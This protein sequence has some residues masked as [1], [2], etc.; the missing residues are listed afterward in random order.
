MDLYN[1]AWIIP[2][3]N[4]A[5][6]RDNYEYYDF[7]K[8]KNAFLFLLIDTGTHI[9]RIINYPE[10]FG[11]TYEYIK[12]EYKKYDEPLYHEGDARRE[13]MQRCIDNSFIRIRFNEKRYTYTIELKE[14]TEENMNL[15][16]YFSILTN[17]KIMKNF[18][19]ENKKI[20]SEF[21]A[22]RL[23]KIFARSIDIK[24]LELYD[25]LYEKNNEF[26]FY[27]IKSHFINFDFRIIEHK[28]NTQRI[29]DAKNNLLRAI[30]E[31]LLSKNNE[32][33]NHYIL[34]EKLLKGRQ[35]V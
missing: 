4:S 10:L 1:A 20:F 3:K 31:I 27:N 32:F 17:K 15:L 35:N 29:Y 26:I 12:S 7:K 25:D 22:I 23:L 5:Y 28:T 14:E 16:A 24:N 34:N 18:Y 33:Q 11:L 6:F 13:I 9:D 30:K 19:N 21:N 8:A 2:V